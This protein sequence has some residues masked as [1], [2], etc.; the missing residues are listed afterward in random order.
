MSA[1]R[2]V[3]SDI[4]P[5]A[6]GDSRVCHLC[7]A[8]LPLA[9]M[10]EIHPVPGLTLYRCPD[11]CARLAAVFAHARERWCWDDEACLGELV[12]RYWRPG[13]TPASFVDGF[14]RDY[15][16]DDPRQPWW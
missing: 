9:Q 12:E 10:T 3:A 4:S 6:A 1:D 13:D 7:L 2:Y 8:G 16:L 15:E 5:H 11:C 14:A